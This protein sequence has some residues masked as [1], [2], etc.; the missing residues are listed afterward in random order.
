MTLHNISQDYFGVT[1]NLMSFIKSYIVAKQLGM[2]LAMHNDVVKSIKFTSD[3]RVETFSDFFGGLPIDVFRSLKNGS[4]ANFDTFI[5]KRFHGKFGDSFDFTR[6]VP[7]VNPNRDVVMFYEWFPKIH[8]VSTNSINLKIHL[9]E[10]ISGNENVTTFHVKN[11]SLLNVGV[12]IEI[13]EYVIDRYITEFKPKSVMFVG[14]CKEMVDFFEKKYKSQTSLKRNHYRPLYHREKGD[15]K[16]LLQDI[17]M[18]A[19][20]TF[21][22][23]D[24]LH[25]RYYSEIKDKYKTIPSELCFFNSIR[26]KKH[27]FDDDIYMSNYFDMF[28]V[29]QKKYGF[30]IQSI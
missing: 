28:V 22:T 12:D 9:N 11:K 14:G 23:N 8:P 3:I 1:T 2:D 19:D 10:K 6:N 7:T 15:L 13:S 16:S 21:V 29:L 5:F 26:Y 24:F 30:I 20:S 27:I 18:C 4:S 17:C 25:E